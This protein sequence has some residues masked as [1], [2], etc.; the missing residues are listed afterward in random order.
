MEAAP[1]PIETIHSSLFFVFI[2]RGVS[3][4][5]KH[6]NASH[7]TKPRNR[8][9]I[10]PWFGALVYVGPESHTV[11][12]AAIGATRSGQISMNPRF[13]IILPNV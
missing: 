4:Q 1:A 13:F 5:P 6:E 8:T 3:K 7:V 11:T 2:M 12:I 9:T 10:A